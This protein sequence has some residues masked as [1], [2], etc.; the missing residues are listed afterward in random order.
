MASRCDGNHMFPDLE[1]HVQR[2]KTTTLIIGGC[3]S[4]KSRHAIE[5]AGRQ[6]AARKIFL[7][8]SVPFDE[9]MKQRVERHRK[10]RGRAWKTVEAPLELAAAMLSNSAAG[11]L[12]VVDCLTLWLNNLL[13]ETGDEKLIRGRF[14]ELIAVLGRMTCPVYL[15]SNEVGA[16][17]VPENDLAR[18]FRDLAGVLNQEAAAAADTVFWMVAGIPVQVK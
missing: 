12:V 1:L 18:Q 5:V 10:E 11:N 2:M 3:K 9:E 4:G 16:G 14:D 6:A 13:M 8:T 15:V 17:I 7:A